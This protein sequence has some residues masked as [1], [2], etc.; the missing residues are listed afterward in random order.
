M[1]SWHERR[2][3]VLS[4]RLK[5]SSPL[6]ESQST[7][8]PPPVPPPPPFLST[9][10]PPLP[11]NV[12]ESVLT[13]PITDSV[14]PMEDAAG[15]PSS[16]FTYEPRN[17][18][19]SACKWTVP[20]SLRQSIAATRTRPLYSNYFPISVTGLDCRLLLYPKGDSQSLPGHLSL[21]L[22]LVDPTS[23]KSPFDRFA[24]YRLTL[25]H[26]TDAAKSVLRDSWHRFSNKKKSHGWCD[27]SPVSGFEGESLTI[28][29][30]ISLLQETTSLSPHEGKFTWRL[31][32]LSLF[33]T[34]MKTQKITSPIFPACTSTCTGT[35]TDTGLK[36]SIYQ[37]T[38]QGSGDHLS[39][40][41]ESKEDYSATTNKSS[42]NNTNTEPGCW[43]LF[44]VT[45]MNQVQQ[46]GTGTGT[47]VSKDSYGRFG[48]DGASLGWTDFMKMD[49]F[50]GKGSNGSGYVVNGSAVI[51]VSY[52]VIK[53]SCVVVN[54]GGL[55]RGGS[56]NK[57]DGG[58]YFGKFTWRIEGF[59]KLKDI[60]KRR[61]ISGICIKS[62]KFQVGGRDCRLIVYPRGQSQP[63]RHL[64]V[65]LEVTD[66]RS[67][68]SQPDWTCF[69]SHRL[70]IA[71]QKSDSN[72]V[73]KES[74]NRYSKTAKDWG[75][76][77]FVTLTSL[78][79]QDSGFLVNDTVVFCA[80]VAVLKESTELKEVER[81]AGLGIGGTGLMS[82]V[83][84]VENF[85]AFKEIM[86]TRKI[87][88][89]FFQV[90]GCEL[91]I[92][93]YESFDTICIYLESDP[94]SPADPD[95]NFWVRYR[96]GILNQKS[97]S[98]T[99]WRESSI[100][101][102]TWNNS[103]LQFMKVQ[104]MVSAE[105]GFVARDS[106]VFVCEVMDCCPWFEFSD[107]EVFA[108]E[109]EKEE[110]LTTDQDEPVSSED[111]QTTDYDE[112]LPTAVPN[113]NRDE[114]FRNLL[115]R[116]GF[117][118]PEPSGTLQSS[119]HLN[120]REKILTDANAIA[121]FLTG[122]RVYL[123]HPNKVKQMLLPGASASRSVQQADSAG[124]GPSSLINLLMGVSVLKQAIVDL[125]LDI[126]VECCE[127]ASSCLEGDVG[128]TG[129]GRVAETGSGSD[130]RSES[131]RSFGEGEAGS[132]E[133]ASS[134]SQPL[135]TKWP[136]QSEELLTLILNSLRALDSTV[137]SS[138]GQGQPA[139]SRRRAGGSVARKLALVLDKVPRRFLP[140]LVG[141]VPKLVDGPEEHAAA[142]ELLVDMVG[143]AGVEAEDVELRF[144]IFGALSQLEFGSEIWENVLNQAIKLL[145]I[146]SDES[147]VAAI[148]CT[149]NSASHCHLLSS[150]ARAIRLK[151]K[152]LGT[153]APH[154]VLDFLCKTIHTWSDVARAFLSEIDADQDLFS[155]ESSSGSNGSESEPE[156]F[157]DAYL[158]L[159][160][161][162]VPTLF[163]DVTQVLERGLALGARWTH[164]VAFALERRRSQEDPEMVLQKKDFTAVMALC[165]VMAISSESKV[166]EFV[167]TLYMILFRVY[168]D[169]DYRFRLIKTLILRATNSGRCTSSPS[170]EPSGTPDVEMDALLSLIREDQA[171][172]GPV[173]RMMREAAEVAQA[174]RAAL[175]HQVCRA[176]DENVRLREERDGERERFDEERDGL[177]RRLE[178]GEASTSSL[179]SELKEE[180]DRF[181]RE[182][183]NLTDQI[184]DLEVQLEWVRSEKDEKI[185]KLLHEKKNLQDRLR[186][187]DSQLNQLKSRKKEELKKVMKEKNAMGER[188]KAAESARKRY[189]EELKRYAS[190]TAARKSLE[191]EVRRLRET[192]ESS[193]REK[194]EKEEQVVRCEAYIDG[195]ESKLQA[196]QQ[197]INTL[198]TSLQEEMTRHAPLYGVG[199]ETLTPSELDT[200]ARIHEE[201]LQQIHS[202][203]QQQQRNPNGNHINNFPQVAPSIQQPPQ[204]N[205]NGN[206]IAN[207]PQVAPQRNPNGNSIASFP[208]VA[209][210]MQ[211]RRSSTS[212]NH[213]ASQVGPNMQ[214]QRNPSGNLGSQVGSNMQQ[215]RN[216]NGN[217]I[218]SQ[219]RSGGGNS[220]ANCTQVVPGLF[221]GPPQVKPSPIVPPRGAG[222]QGNEHVNG[223]I[224]PWFNPT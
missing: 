132:D 150:A 145:E 191:T 208:Q 175:W 211:Q 136:E 117:P 12:S 154:C 160:M 29:C 152:K 11:N 143:R 57:A 90:G 62:K 63:P 34:M 179:K 204:R 54:K 128:S 169:N 86:E 23:S 60:L 28:T 36:L 87:F 83:W 112:D 21:Y 114:L 139:E 65:F 5:N 115:V 38:V 16:Q 100:C 123:N 55:V 9:N 50:L 92:G 187:M 140:E 66:P 37:S 216:P 214:R 188:L 15:S 142:A 18:H 45:V 163:M 1:L 212:G 58:G 13:T 40:C 131:D 138:Q 167:C 102:K 52:H 195:M 144:Q 209:P 75:W 127:P 197:Y 194:R 108:S 105:A 192:A 116:A 135:E 202:I 129:A 171:T 155:D 69:V 7:R 70:S 113:P 94:P 110:T 118:L 124:S 122:L 96:M 220:N 206:S 222:I 125:L 89:K 205:P 121:T 93:V 61:K 159:E 22:Q 81:D 193:E 133:A 223:P 218:A 156:V 24:S 78:F 95:R 120:L 84:K 213:V 80:E 106:V 31:H 47:H 161:L 97:A 182:K 8:T 173:L 119:P 19:S 71:N 49:E 46:N 178:E 68:T 42:Q 2:S 99:V 32:N 207:F 198:E 170:P 73:S 183:R 151:L 185:L 74:Q 59:A 104:E 33:Q 162:Q 82:F 30:D 39:V 27:F 219:Q 56:V 35:G 189:D 215:Q 174:D 14:S 101:T 25:H 88:S 166:L 72:S 48:A 210:S 77:E 43:I 146:S 158:L 201:G 217:S 4:L 79:D 20:A 199:L 64:S 153:E 148:G 184:R 26:P 203:Q 53:E 149:L 177:R 181:A 164:P 186:D 196:C 109:D 85:S 44:R 107:L 180:K 221:S 190:E 176:E 141:L 76:R 157:S 137:P 67:A 172:A 17:D 3:S 224:G 10:P 103:V 126:M 98:K 91:R 6:P 51:S 200:V 134:S 41:L 147:L 111:E 168:P 130:A 165:E